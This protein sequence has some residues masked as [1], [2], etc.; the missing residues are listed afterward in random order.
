VGDEKPPR[1]D[2][3]GPAT[4]AAFIVGL[5]VLGEIAR[6]H[7][8]L[9]LTTSGWGI[10]GLIVVIVASLCIGAWVHTHVDDR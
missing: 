6:T 8:A 5:L 4:A 1:R 9:N 10:V 3:S 7:P 2:L